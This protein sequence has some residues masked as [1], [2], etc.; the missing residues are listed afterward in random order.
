MKYL[1][2]LFLVTFSS[3]TFVNAFGGFGRPV[4]FIERRINHLQLIQLL[5]LFRFELFASMFWY[6]QV[7]LQIKEMHQLQ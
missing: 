7:Y 1:F 6:L 5:L 4:S 3:A 2:T